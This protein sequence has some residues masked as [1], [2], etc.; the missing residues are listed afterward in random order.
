MSGVAVSIIGLLAC[1]VVYRIG[2]IEG[3]LAEIIEILKGKQ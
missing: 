3:K 1:F 2:E